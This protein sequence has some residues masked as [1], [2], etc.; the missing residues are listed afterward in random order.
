MKINKFFNE[1]T[2]V[3]IMQSM[4]ILISGLFCYI[5]LDFKSSTEKSI[6]DLLTQSK[7][8]DIEV[9]T[10]KETVSCLLYTSDAAD[11]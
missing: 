5:L 11:D 7:Q 9:V 3:V 6:N 4:I 2:I 10:L 1:K 8:T